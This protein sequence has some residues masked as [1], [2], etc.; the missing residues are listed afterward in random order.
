LNYD[1]TIEPAQ[2]VARVGDQHIL[3]G[4]ILP[5][6]RQTLEPH[7]DKMTPAQFEQQKEM[8]MV[9]VL[10]QAVDAKLMY[11]AFLRDIPA[12]KLEDAMPQIRRRMSE[13]YDEK[14]LPD[15]LKK[16]KVASAQQFDAILRKFGSSLAKHKQQ[17]MER[18]LG[19][20]AVVMNIDIHPEVT[21]LEMLDYYRENLAEY[22]FPS[23]A[24]W[25]KMTVRFDKT[26][27]EQQAW[28]AIQVLGNE[29]RLGGAPLSAVAKR[30]SQG[31]DASE[32]GYHDWTEP[33]ELRS[34]PID[35]AIFQLP[36]GYLSE[37]I[38]DESGFHIVR[39]VERT[40]AGR[41]PFL[42]AQVEIKKEIVKKKRSEQV[43]EFVASLRESIPV[44]T[45]Y[46]DPSGSNADVAG[47][48][49]GGR[50]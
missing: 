9:Q 7:R 29:V 22:E 23:R 3:A 50:R 21:H 34:Q 24:R 20:Q 11:A 37:I 18:E 12:D 15:A 32:G 17:F 42:D 2:I 48:A 41:K 19:R 27:S 39:V 30:S 8:A 36:P 49:T 16:A 6:V 25:E 35:A 14:E 46:D 33:G 31:L 10:K 13:A 4:D 5:F 28:Q 38:K 40:A 45:I 26:Q 1:D 43:A 47:G 44:W